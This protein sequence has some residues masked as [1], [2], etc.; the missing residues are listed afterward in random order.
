MKKE[1]LFTLYKI[2]YIYKDLS[3]PENTMRLEAVRIF[4][5]NKL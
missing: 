4:I 3:K 5:L 2:N 1:D